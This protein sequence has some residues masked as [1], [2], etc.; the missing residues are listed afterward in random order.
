VEAEA[1]GREVVVGSPRFLQSRRVATDAIAQA[2]AGAAGKTVWVT[3]DRRIVGR[4]VLADHLRPTAR[5]AVAA[6]QR[7]GVQSVMLTGDERPVAEQMAAAAGIEE[8]HAGLLPDEKVK[9][10]R[11]LAKGGRSTLMVGDGVNDAPALA[12]A[13]VGVAM[14]AAGTDLAIEAADVVLMTSSL[15]QLVDAVALGRKARTI[16]W[17]NLLFAAGVIVALITLTLVGLL[18]MSIGV[19]AHE[20]STLLVV[21]NGLRMLAGGGSASRAVATSPATTAPVRAVDAA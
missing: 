13:D 11:K 17:Q 14:G 16:L 8:F 3:V 18:P 1:E 2:P 6:L 4:V 19:A 12:S 9:A 21:L 20:G 5:A 7:L 15:D 10:L